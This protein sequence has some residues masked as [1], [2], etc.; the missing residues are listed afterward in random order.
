MDLTAAPNAHRPP[1]VSLKDS[2]G[3]CSI[4]ASNHSVS[5]RL[6]LNRENTPN[7]SF[8]LPLRFH[9][10]S[11]L[12]FQ[13]IRP[14]SRILKSGGYHAQLFPLGMPPSQ[15]SPRSR[16]SSILYFHQ[17]SKRLPRNCIPKATRLTLHE[18]TEIPSSPMN[19]IMRISAPL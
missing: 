9:P 10:K 4:P 1:S 16:R 6:R 13:F 2:S 7:E 17:T 18:M 14:K 3:A 11:T 12:Y 15:W 5:R 19:I 8:S